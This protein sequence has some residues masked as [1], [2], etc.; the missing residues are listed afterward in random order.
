MT[1][2]PPP[3][4]TPPPPPPPPNFPPPGGPMVPSD[5]V[6]PTQ[7]PK[8]PVL[9]VIL[10][11]LFGGAGYFYIGQWQKGLVGVITTFVLLVMTLLLLGVC[12]GVFL[13]PVCVGLA[14]FLAFD[15]H[16]QATLLR[17]GITLGQWT[18]F[19]DHR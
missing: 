5:L 15:V 13:L 11:L 19:N 4:A 1:E 7:P 16:K 18:F 3:G 14:I 10:N 12:V 17:S 8:D 9:A 6:Y 2:F